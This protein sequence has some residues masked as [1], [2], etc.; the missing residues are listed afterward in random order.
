MTNVEALRVLYV[1]LGGSL[2][3]TYEGIADG[4]AVSDYT[5]SSEVI[6]AIAE[7]AASAGIELPKV[8]SADNGDVLTVK[9]GKW[10]KGEIPA[11]L[12]SV[13]ATDNGSVLKVIDGV[14]AVGTDE[15]QA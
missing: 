1:A 15:I 10:A 13:S 4:A 7:I 3:D 2:T 9:S 12:P 6:C 14:W 5:T 8:T 11:E